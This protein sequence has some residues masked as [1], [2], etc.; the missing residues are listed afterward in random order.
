MHAQT[1]KKPLEEEENAEDGSSAVPGKKTLETVSAADSIVDALDMASTEEDRI[2]ESIR[3][4]KQSSLVPNPLMLG[5]SPSDYVLRA[6][7]SVRGSDLEQALLL[8]PFLD[9]LRLLQFLCVWLKRGGDT[10]LLS[11]VAILLCRVHLQQLMSTPAARPTLVELR[12]LLHSRIS[13]LK[14]TWGFNAAAIEF[15]KR[16]LHGKR[17]QDF[18]DHAA[19]TAAKLKKLKDTSAL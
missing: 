15:L 19:T 9:A 16:Q 13:D 7:R 3:D 14:D 5:L 2:A 11:R 4:N 6:V 17:S 1:E 8:V 12:E 18:L 10:E